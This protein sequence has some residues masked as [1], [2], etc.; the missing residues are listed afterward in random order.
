MTS[1]F[2]LQSCP[3]NLSFLFFFS[4][5][6]TNFG[7]CDWD[8]KWIKLKMMELTNRLTNFRL[9]QEDNTF[10]LILLLFFFLFFFKKKIVYLHTSH[11]DFHFHVT[12]KYFLK[13]IFL[14][15][16]LKNINKRNR[17]IYNNQYMVHVCCKS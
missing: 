3:T 11:N 9:Q 14:K 2:N 17:N 15:K 5:W 6:K 16:T 7:R 8:Y 1:P 10:L 12:L 13:I 4:L